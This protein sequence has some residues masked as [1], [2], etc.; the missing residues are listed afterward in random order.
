M[1]EIIATRFYTIDEAVDGRFLPISTRESARKMIKDGRLRAINFGGEGKGA[2]YQILG[3]ELI[4]FQQE[5][6]GEVRT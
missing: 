6:G 1:Q 3:S 2:R 5:E 4:R